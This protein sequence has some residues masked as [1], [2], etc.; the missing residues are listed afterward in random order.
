MGGSQIEKLR[1]E[2][3][4][5][6]VSLTIIFILFLL[7]TFKYIG[8]NQIQKSVSNSESKF[9][10]PE[11][12]GSI[13]SNAVTM[14][15]P[16][17]DREGKGVIATITVEA[18]RGRGK[19]LV[20]IEDLFFFLDTQES[21]LI[22]KQVA[23]DITNLDL[24]NYDLIYTIHTNANS[25]GGPSAGA[26]LTIATIAA[27]QNLTLKKDVTITGRILSDGSI[28]SVS[29]ILQKAE[30]AKKV[31]IKTF[32]V[33]EGQSYEVEYE[34]KRTCEK[35]LTT[36]VCVIE[37]IPKKENISKKVGIKVVEVSTIEE[38]I[39]YFVTPLTQE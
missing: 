31:G 16:A 32:L 18:K 24:S 4:F 13:S 34:T 12:R 8:S 6:V 20:D 9:S 25:V 28:G 19:T 11:V 5:L 37:K 2:N 29:G 26:A 38:A 10:V 30:A 27:L 7:V 22:A 36:E 21:I 33:P 3:R 35:K 1:R 15:V 39:K 23:H 14:N 17:I